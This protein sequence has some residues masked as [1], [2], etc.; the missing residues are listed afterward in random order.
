MNLRSL[1]LCSLFVCFLSASVFGQILNGSFEIFEPNGNPPVNQPVDWECENYAVVDSNLVP[2]ADRNG[3]KKWEID[4]EIGLEP[5][6][7][8]SFVIV[9]SG[10]LD[11]RYGE[12]SQVWQ[13]V[14]FFAGQKIS[15][16]YF[17]GTYDY[18]RWND[19]GSI[20]LEPDDSNDPT[21][22]LARADVEDVGD[23]SSMSDW[24]AFVHV[25]TEE[26]AG[27]YDI[28]ISVSNLLDTSLAS[29]FAVDG[30]E[31]C[32]IAPYGDVNSDCKVD[33]VD[34]DFLS[35]DWM[36]YDPNYVQDPNYWRQYETDFDGNHY[37]G[38]GDLSLMADY[39]L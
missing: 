17:F 8:N 39:W 26:D 30:L 34:F 20:I 4:Y 21:I 5:F 12:V 2:V 31:V 36:L 35:Q 33:L 18:L 25:F 23:Y 9:N 15:G 32:T 38:E 16:V 10:D 11:P 14:E 6:D 1:Y 24:E 3:G 7:G 37:V 22:I 29:Y 13:S 19:F 28:V 27:V